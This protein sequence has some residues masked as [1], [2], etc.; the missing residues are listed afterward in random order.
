MT[1]KITRDV[2]KISRSENPV[3]T[4]RAFIN[5][6]HQRQIRNAFLSYQKVY[7]LI[8]LQSHST[9]INQA[10]GRNS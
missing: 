6:T 3:L 1:K 4:W 9:A 5:C 8:F 10:E 7:G 2:N